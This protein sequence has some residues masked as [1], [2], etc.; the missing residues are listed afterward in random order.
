[1]TYRLLLQTSRNSSLN[2]AS[3]LRKMQTRK[4]RKFVLKLRMSLKANTR[5]EDYYLNFINNA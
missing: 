2:Q 4:Q 3:F 5:G 1:M